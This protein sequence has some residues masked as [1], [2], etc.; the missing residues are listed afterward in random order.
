M[1]AFVMKILEVSGAAK[2]IISVSEVGLDWGKWNFVKVV[3]NSCLDKSAYLEELQRMVDE[4]ALSPPL[5][6]RPEKENIAY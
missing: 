4:Y 2:D 1:N 5:K 6:I 3:K